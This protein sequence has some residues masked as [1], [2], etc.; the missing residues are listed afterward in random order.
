MF[1]TH[2]LFDQIQEKT[3]GKSNL[4]F[5]TRLRCIM[6]IKVKPKLCEYKVLFKNPIENLLMHR[7]EKKA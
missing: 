4:Y 1:Y 5:G 2:V 3:S 7:L 6:L